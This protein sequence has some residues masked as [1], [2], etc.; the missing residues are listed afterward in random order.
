MMILT[1]GHE[2]GIDIGIISLV[3]V[4]AIIGDLQEHYPVACDEHC[5]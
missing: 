3:A 2:G 4:G 5:P 1:H